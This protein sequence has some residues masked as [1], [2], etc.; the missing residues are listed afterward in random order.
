MR[1]WQLRGYWNLDMTPNQRKA[2]SAQGMSLLEEVILDVL[3][4]AKEK[5]ESCLGAAEIA[6]RGQMHHLPAGVIA[7]WNQGLQ[8]HLLNKMLNEGRPIRKCAKNGKYPI[9][10]GQGGWSAV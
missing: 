8:T 10:K 6:R 1:D 3:Q 2:Q 9:Q 5:G 4:E 7:N